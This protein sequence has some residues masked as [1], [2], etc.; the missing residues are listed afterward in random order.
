MNRET[1]IT[2]ISQLHNI[3]ERLA[4]C[5]FPTVDLNTVRDDLIAFADRIYGVP[6]P[7][8]NDP[9]NWKVLASGAESFSEWMLA[10]MGTLEPSKN[11]EL[12]RLAQ[13]L[14]HAWNVTPPFVLFFSDGDYAIHYFV[15]DKLG[16][17]LISKRYNISFHKEPKFITIPGIYS[18]DMGFGSAVYHEVGHMVDQAYN[19]SDVVYIKLFEAIKTKT[20]CAITSKYFPEVHDK[21]CIDEDKIRA[22]ISEYIADVFACQ[23]LGK[24]ALRFVNYKEFTG[25]NKSRDNHPTLACRETLMNSFVDYASKQ[26]PSTSDF[27]LQFIIDSFANTAGLLPLQKRFYALNEDSLTRGV[28]LALQTD[29]ER[30]SLCYAYW[31][32][33]DKGI[34]NMEAVQGVAHGSITRVQFYDTVNNAVKASV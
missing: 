27:F 14:A 17:H 28:P 30:F 9:N 24:H 6:Q 12:E 13:S 4:L 18:G 11:P 25:R 22:H 33:I 23:Y 10:L 19:L 31:E 15:K 8:I 5:N 16:K 21:S 29:E 7:E 2:A 32:I 20:K 26:H 3:R 1:L 34:H